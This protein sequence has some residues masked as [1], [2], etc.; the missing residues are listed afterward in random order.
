MD[1]WVSFDHHY[2]GDS[3][4]KGGGYSTFRQALLW[5]ECDCSQ[6]CL[7]HG[8]SHRFFATVCVIGDDTKQY[9]SQNRPLRD[10][11]SRWCLSQHWAVDPY[12]LDVTIQPIPHPPNSPSIKPVPFQFREKEVVG[13]CV[14]GFTEVQIGDMRS[15]SLV[16]WCS[17]SIIEGH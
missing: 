6:S 14:K 11:T 16:C 2:S 9:W 15:S 3:T 13:D 8:K 12:P 7:T 1:F 10:T 4:E 5:F 17:P